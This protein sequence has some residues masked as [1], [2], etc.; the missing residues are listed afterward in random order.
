MFILY[1]S[2]LS[3]HW[4]NLNYNLLAFMDNFLNLLKSFERVFNELVLFHLIDNEN[5]VYF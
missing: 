1:F 5:I 4:N 2:I 3:F